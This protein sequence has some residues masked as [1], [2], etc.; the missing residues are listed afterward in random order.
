MAEPY[1]QSYYAAT[2][3]QPEPFGRLNGRLEVDVAV[4]GGGFTGVATALE[5]AEKGVSVALLEA[6]LIG[7][8]ASSR[9]GGQITGSLSGDQAML[10]QFRRVLGDGAE[11][12]VWNLRWRG[13]D[14]I[15][16]RVEKYAIRCDLK[17]GHMHAAFKSSHVA[18]LE[19]TYRAARAHGTGDDV[20]MV[21]GTAVRDVIGTDIYAAGLINRRN[22]HVHSL[23]LCLGEADAARSLGARIFTGTKVNEIRHGRR[24]ELVTDGGSVHAERVLLAGNASHRLARAKLSGLLFPATL[25]IVTTEPLSEAMVQDINPQDL[26]VYDTRF[27]LDYYRLTADR[28]LLF[29]SGTNY[30]G[31]ETANLKDALRPAI[32][33]TFPQLKGIGIDFAWQGQD[34]ITINRIPQLGRIADNVFYAQG[35]SGH[36]VATSHIVGEI[37]ASALTGDPRQLDIFASARHWRLPVGRFLGNQALA[38]GMWYF[39][40]R[41]KRR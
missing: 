22:M 27:V 6:N 17:F 21:Y 36:G 15:R 23:N 4:I 9:N 28:R 1:C 39:Q 16:R 35:Y 12:F 14:I 13:H 33:K 34:G 30:T 7:W 24:V 25:G 5:L 26:A 38:I 40:R 3:N 10:R 2:A 29:G 18:E 11:D 31:R 8:G 37:M 32:E 20:E 19:Q 41:E